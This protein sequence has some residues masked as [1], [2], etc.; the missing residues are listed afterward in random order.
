MNDQNK[1]KNVGQ[2]TNPSQ[3]TGT[4]NQN[5]KQDKQQDFNKP[6]QQPV[7]NPGMGSSKTDTKTDIDQGGG[8]MPQSSKGQQNKIDELDTEDLDE[9]V[10]G[11]TSGRSSV[12]KDDFSKR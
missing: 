4:G 9:D 11:S 1:N 3:S 8:R 7:K 12:K 2:N 10:T 5:I 6:G